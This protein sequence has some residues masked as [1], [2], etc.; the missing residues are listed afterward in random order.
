MERAMGELRRYLSPVGLLRRAGLPRIIEW[1]LVSFMYLWIAGFVVAVMVATVRGY[2]GA[3]REARAYER[4]LSKVP[5]PKELKHAS[6][7]GGGHAH[8][9]THGDTG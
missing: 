6:T 2:V 5:A 9:S 3:F 4:S 8:D 1:L 7:T